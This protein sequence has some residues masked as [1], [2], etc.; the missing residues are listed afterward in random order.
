M[1]LNIRNLCISCLGII[2]GVILGLFIVLLYLLKGIE[3]S[4]LI[5]LSL[6]LPFWF[7]PIMVRYIV[8]PQMN[9]ILRLLANMC[10]MIGSFILLIVIL[11]IVTGR[12]T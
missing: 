9:N 12:G 4:L 3:M 10:L 2:I 11:L 7:I 6:T 8:F 1:R 5:L